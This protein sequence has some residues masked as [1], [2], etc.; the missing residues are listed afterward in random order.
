M[1]DTNLRAGSDPLDASP[2]ASGQDALIS[3]LTGALRPVRRLPG[4]W[5]RTALWLCGALWMCL[6][7]AE[8]ADLAALR[9]RL[10]GEPDLWIA[11]LASTAT[12]VLA[13]AAAFATSIPGR[14]ARWGLLPLPALAVW[15]GASAAGAM[16]TAQAPFTEAEPMMHSMECIYVIVLV[17][18]PLSILIMLQL[19]RACPLRPGLTAALGGLASAGAAATALALIHP[20]DANVV[21]LV[22]HGVAVA[23]VVGAN[24]LLGAR[25]VD[26]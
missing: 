19:L 1:S 26:G 12:A 7:L 20:Y 8:F 14:S 3:R 10:M 15:I 17:A 9:H 18:V 6:L 25:A 24:R 16:R 11:F 2:G 23:L 22:A 21:D 13:A 5:H 4:P